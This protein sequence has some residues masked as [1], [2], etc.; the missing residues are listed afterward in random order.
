MNAHAKHTILK[1]YRWGRVTWCWLASQKWRSLQNLTCP[2]RW[3]SESHQMFAFAATLSSGEH[4]I[5]R[6]GALTLDNSTGHLVKLEWVCSDAR[7][8]GWY[9]VII[10]SLMALLV[11]T[12]KMLQRVYRIGRKTF[13]SFF[14]PSSCGIL[15]CRLPD[16]WSI[17]IIVMEIDRIDNVPCS[18]CE[19]LVPCE[20][21][22]ETSSKNFS[23]TNF[24]SLIL[25]FA[26]LSK[27]WEEGM[28]G[29]T[30]SCLV[31]Y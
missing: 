29:K 24:Q 10:F 6:R 9:L 15:C 18:H 2:T 20:H 26:L 28:P 11:F 31:K 27:R 16:C 4:P 3:I 22:P 17:K 13:L 1:A 7:K 14:F 12:A 23:S 8:E 19:Q 5:R 30:Q 25:F 21:N